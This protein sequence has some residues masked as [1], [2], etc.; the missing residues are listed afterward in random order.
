MFVTVITAPLRGLGYTASLH[1]SISDHG[2]ERQHNAGSKVV[3][4]SVWRPFDRVGYGCCSSMMVG[5]K[6]N[7]R[8]NS[9]YYLIRKV[10]TP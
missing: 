8:G 10:I 3:I 6:N 5:S 4:L 9:K 2:E 1:A 7:G